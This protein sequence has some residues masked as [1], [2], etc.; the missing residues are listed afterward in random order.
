MSLLN[1]AHTRLTHH[2]PYT[3]APCLHILP[4]VKTRLHAFTITDKR[5]TRLFYLVC[6]VSIVRHGLS[7][8]NPRKATAPDFLPL[9]FI[10]FASN[11][12]DSHLYNIIK[13]VEINKYSEE[14][15]AEL[16]RPIFKRNERDKVGNYRPVS[17]LNGMSKIYERCIHNS[18]SSYAE[19]IL[20]NFI[21]AFKK[22]YSSNHILLKVH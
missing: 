20:S 6:A 5:V 22:S 8:K 17:I 16:V 21:S 12:I 11:V 3:P 15:K 13:D 9:K 2:V 19:T 1:C 14:P 10:K 4:I 18:L 7:R